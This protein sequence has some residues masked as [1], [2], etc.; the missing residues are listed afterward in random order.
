M[1]MSI[2]AA[3][4][5]R[6]QAEERAAA[7]RARDA[8]AAAAD[9]EFRRTMLPRPAAAKYLGVAETTLRDWWA[10]GDRG[11]AGVK[12]SPARQGRVFYPLA[13]LDAWKADPLAYSRRARPESIG[14]F[15]P[16]RRGSDKRGPKT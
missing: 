11:P 1:G 12:L 13:E 10:A 15:E 2:R 16:P 9:A 3:R 6:Q 4:Y 8:E 7:K 5:A 14:P